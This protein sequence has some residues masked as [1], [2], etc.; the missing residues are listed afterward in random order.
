MQ[1]IERHVESLDWISLIL[2]GAFMLLSL[3]KTAYP[4]RFEDFTSLLTSNKFMVFRGKE[5][6]AFHPFNIL[7]FLVN[8]LSVSLF[9]FLVFQLLWPGKITTSP[10]VLFVRIATGYA[11]FILL[12]FGVEKIIA[13][14]FDLDRIIDYYLY[15]KLAYRNFMALLLFIPLLFFFYAFPPTT[16]VLS[17]ILGLVILTNIIS[18][19]TIYKQNQTLISTN[20]F[21]FILYLCALEIA[22]YI[23]LYKL[24]TI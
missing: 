19:A 7:M 20:W 23:I 8:I 24:I 5:Y 22:P 17:I 2:L 21:Y 15:Q 16:L 18:L 10:I 1:A 12:K 11:S 13:N 9:L 3:V 4:Q 14:I 6:K